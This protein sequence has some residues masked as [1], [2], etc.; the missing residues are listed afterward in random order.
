MGQLLTACAVA[1][2]NTVATKECCVPVVV[3]GNILPLVTIPKV[4]CAKHDAWVAE[5][6]WLV[7]VGTLSEIMCGV[8]A[9]T[10]IGSLYVI[11][12]KT[13]ACLFDCFQ[14]YTE[15][16]SSWAIPP[17]FTTHRLDSTSNL[18]K[19]YMLIP[20]PWFTVSRASMLLG[21]GLGQDPENWSIWL[22]LN[23]YYMFLPNRGLPLLC[24]HGFFL[25]EDTSGALLEPSSTASHGLTTIP[26]FCPPPKPP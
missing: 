21:P 3:V 13:A 12:V 18:F 26:E 9:G 11:A 20:S 24:Q 14:I 6:L 22:K 17:P 25:C 23:D 1:I 15:V 4:A 5:K 19:V 2:D 8:C 16:K 10:L 7:R